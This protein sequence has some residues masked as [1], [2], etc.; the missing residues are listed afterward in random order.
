MHFD[1]RLDRPAAL[2]AALL[3]ICTAP[4]SPALA[5]SGSA[6]PIEPTPAFAGQTDAPPPAEASAVRVDVITDA[7]T[8]PWAV[9]FLP[10]G[11][12][13]VTERAGT[14]RTVSPDGSVSQPIAGVPPVKVV[15]A[16]GFHDV[17][18]DP[19]FEQN[20]LV[21]FTY[22]APPKGEAAGEWPVEHFYEEVWE[23]PFHERRVMDLGT[24]R[25]GRARLSEDN[26]RLEDVEV[27]IE[28]RV[29]RRIVF[30]PDGTLFVTGAD[31]FRFY[32]SDLDGVER[33]FLDNPDIPRNFSG[34][35]IR[36][37][38]DGTIPADNPWL[39]RATVARE[40]Y[41]HGLK[42]PEGAAIH[43]ETGEL[44]VIDH[45]P[46][47]GDEIDI[48]RPGRDYGW[49]NVSYG[50]QYDAR[51]ADGRRNVPVGTGMT[52][53]PGVEEP[54]YY[55]VP[56]IA[57]SGMAFYTGDLFPEWRGN[58]FVGA[59]AGRHLVRLV[60]DGERVVA[61]ERLLENLDLRI[62][63]VRQGPDGA[64]YLLGGNQLLRVTPP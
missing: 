29:E 16:Q 39:S 5:Q 7:L 63:E 13:L 25:V 51:Q 38:P 55:W 43:P 21:Y 54:V 61:E 26:T 33:D 28:G 14:L 52:S 45:G 19:G 35:V 20:R 6:G 41:A 3:L 34:R 18:L 46:Q 10:D 48:V 59:M 15:A 32:D 12:F 30:A 4:A 24:E 58:L 9:A 2:A 22:F 50:V 36:L 40:T 27:L 1:L 44:W 53:M 57:P 62:R 31:A 37:N 64:L 11:S 49:P 56:S 47:G 23:K 17:V 42:D 8:S 60:L